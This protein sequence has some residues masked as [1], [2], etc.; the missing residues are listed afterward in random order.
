MNKL[1]LQTKFFLDACLPPPNDE[2]Y[3]NILGFSR[4]ASPKEIRQEYVEK[5]R[6]LHPAI[7]NPFCCTNK[8]ECLRLYTAYEV[9]YEAEPERETLPLCF[10]LRQLQ[11]SHQV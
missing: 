1:E 9:C 11:N 8:E 3:C 4:Y 6:I 5:A 10:V 7:D 2:D